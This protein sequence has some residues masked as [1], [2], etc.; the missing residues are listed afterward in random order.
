MIIKILS[1]D[2]KRISSDAMSKE[3]DSHA[4]LISGEKNTSG[5]LNQREKMNYTTVL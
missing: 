4:H 5:L 2:T 1:T 3:R